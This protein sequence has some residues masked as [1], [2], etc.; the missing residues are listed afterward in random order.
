MI[1]GGSN[2]FFKSKP[3][4]GPTRK[5][6]RHSSQRLKVVPSKVSRSTRWLRGTWSGDQDEGTVSGVDAG[7]VYVDWISSAHADHDLSASPPSRLQKAK[8]LILLPCFSHANW[9]LG[10]WYKGFERGNPHSRL[11]EIF[12]IIKTRTKV[13]VVWQDGTLGLEL[14]SQ[15]L[16]PVGVVNAHEFW[17]RQF[18]LEKVTINNSQKWGVDAKERTVKVQWRN[19]HVNQINGFNADQNSDRGICY[20]L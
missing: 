8:D 14:D 18:V 13:D 15:P 5:R 10:D 17:P 11:E 6:P 19:M 7:F 3:N 1:G 4:S 12:A 20:F 9:Q 2:P 16:V